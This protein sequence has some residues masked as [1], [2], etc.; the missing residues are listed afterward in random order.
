MKS[1][2]MIGGGLQQVE[3]V[4]EARKLGFFVIVTDKNKSAPCFENADLSVVLDGKDVKSISKFINKNKK[5]LNILGVFTCVNLAPTVAAVANKC[6]LPGI[7]S[8]IA[9]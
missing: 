1:V 3:A 8:G 6:N 4:N 5:R 7:A 2:V 9:K